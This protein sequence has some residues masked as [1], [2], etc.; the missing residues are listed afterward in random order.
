MRNEDKP[1]PAHAAAEGNISRV[2]RV[3]STEV[4]GKKNFI[5][6]GAGGFDADG[7]GF[8]LPGNP[9]ERAVARCRVESKL[10]DLRP[11]TGRHE[12]KEI[13]RGGAQLDRLFEN[14]RQL[15]HI[16]LRHRGVHLKRNPR[17]LEEL[18]T[19]QRFFVSILHAAERVMR[20]RRGS[21]QTDADSHHAG[22]FELGRDFRCQQM[23][24]GGEDDAAPLLRGV[25]RHL[26]NVVAHQRLAT[27]QNDHRRGSGGQSIDGF[28]T[29]LGG[30][31]IDIV[32]VARRP[33]AVLALQLAASRNFPG[34]NRRVFDGL[35]H[36]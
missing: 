14:L 19:R 35:M 6:R 27:G 5:L 16:Q 21:I 8:C 29:F 24:A 32:A 3:R 31:L 25:A 26:K 1:A 20:F 2:F 15:V 13:H 33:A 11:A 30:K 4:S 23:P 9:L 18:K 28:E 7:R 36:R 17:I 12:K 22:R 34:D 10:G